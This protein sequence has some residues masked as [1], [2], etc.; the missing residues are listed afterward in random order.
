MWGI[1]AD[2]QRL[3]QDQRIT[4]MYVGNTSRAP[5]TYVDDQGSPPCM[6]G[7]QRVIALAN[8]EIGITPMYVGNT[9]RGPLRRGP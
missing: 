9:D 5:K 8:Q 3:L 6:W 1:L 2:L 4:P 7:I